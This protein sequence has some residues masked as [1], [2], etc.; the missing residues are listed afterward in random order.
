MEAFVEKMRSLLEQKGKLKEIYVPSSLLHRLSL[1]VLFTK[2][3]QGDKV[4]R[5]E[6]IRTVYL[7]YSM[8]VIAR[9]VGVHY[10]TVSKIIKG[11]R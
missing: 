7:G 9:H 4:S 11:E 10:S 5:D 6:T 1:M 2:T 3:M 8:A